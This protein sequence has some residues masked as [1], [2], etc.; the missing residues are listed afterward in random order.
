[1]DLSTIIEKYNVRE[2]MLDRHY[3]ICQEAMETSDLTDDDAVEFLADYLE[4]NN[5]PDAL[6]VANNIIDSIGE[7]LAEEVRERDQE[8][9][10]A[11]HERREA[12]GGEY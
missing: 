5:V 8:A 10:D 4:E 11:E 7:D 6:A 12:M 3:E 1:M 9:I 2:V